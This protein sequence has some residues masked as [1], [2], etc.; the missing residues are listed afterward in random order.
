MI[1]PFSVVIQHLIYFSTYTHPPRH[2]YN[3]EYNKRKKKTLVSI[4]LNSKFTAA[5][6]PISLFIRNG[7]TAA[8]GAAATRCS[9]IW[10]RCSFE[11]ATT[12]RNPVAPLLTRVCFRFSPPHTIPRT[13][14]V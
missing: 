9:I 3:K 1:F 14:D 10:A 12:T 11:I 13:Y 4:S 7:V 8:A 5:K 6:F 2:I